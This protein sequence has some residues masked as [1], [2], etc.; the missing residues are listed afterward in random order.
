MQV[1]QNYRPR[2]LQALL[3]R[4]KSSTFQKV[5]RC[6]A[7]KNI[8]CFN[9]SERCCFQHF[10]VIF[11]LFYNNWKRTAFRHIVTHDRALWMWHNSHCHNGVCAKTYADIYVARASED[12]SPYLYNVCE[13]LGTNY[14]I[15][16]RWPMGPLQQSLPPLDQTSSYATVQHLSNL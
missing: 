13:F 3:A 12:L 15:P 7:R 2:P 10:T 4:K 9:N 6:C 1:Q 16:K 5:R 8:K 11:D 14:C